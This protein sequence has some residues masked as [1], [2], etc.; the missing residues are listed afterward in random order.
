MSDR[1]SK[2][3]VIPGGVKV[4]I[5]GSVY[6][7]S[8]KFGSLD[9][10]SNKNVDV[11]VGDKILV[12]SE[13]NHKQ[14]L[15]TTCSLLRQAVIDVS[16]GVVANLKMVGVGFKA[17]VNGKFLN[18]YVGN[19]HDVV[20]LI[21]DCVKVQ[22]VGDTQLNVSGCNRETVN[23]FVNYIRSIKKP[24]PYKGKGI[25]LNNEVVVRKSGKKK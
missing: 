5:N 8:G 10:V 19:S 12:S 6:S 23:S 16:N 21:P 24:E 14:Y 17:S 13:Y 15:H 11:S 25:F 4:I 20:F 3:I 7:I 18:L 22:C 1:L 9:I 2:E